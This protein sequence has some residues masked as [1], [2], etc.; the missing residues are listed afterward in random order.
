[1]KIKI[2]VPDW[3]LSPGVM[4]LVVLTLLGGIAAIVRFIHGIGAISNLND[5][6]PWGFWISFDIYTGV[7][8][9]AG[10]FT[11]AAVVYIFDIKKYT[12]LVRPSVLTGFLGYAMVAVG[13]LVDLGRPENIWHMIVYQN[14]HSFL[15][16]IGICVMTYLTVLLF[17]F[18]PV[19]FEGLHFDNVVHF[20]HKWLT[21]PLVILGVVL[22]TLH[23]SSLGSLTIIEPEKLHPLWWTPFI[24]V[25][26]F[27]SAVTVGFA[28]VI[29]ESEMSARA[30]NRSIEIHLLKDVA[31]WIPYGSGLYL[32][33]RFGQLA[34][35]GKLGLLF[36]SGNYTIVFWAEIILFG[37]IPII[38]FAQK[39]M[40]ESPDGLLYGSLSVVLGLVLNRFDVS[41]IMLGGR[42]FTT[43]GY[44]PSLPEVSISVGMV[45]ASLL[46][47]R[48]IA[49]HFPLFVEEE[50][51]HDQHVAYREASQAGD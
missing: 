45:A 1:M 10:A 26:F 24:P 49:L 41:W 34:Y 11:M 40:R 39:K 19:I 2:R 35:E 25:L 31:S 27:V 51:Y 44:V 16:E 43:S 21:L 8:L 20:F 15:F 46:V 42:I 22:S 9:G 32:L 38:M 6:Y 37:I 12:P 5:A 3:M 7:A 28:M 36:T 30:F 47:F 14:H 29:F 33:L 18:L 23:Q 4:T 17:E 48:Y 50:D 13:L